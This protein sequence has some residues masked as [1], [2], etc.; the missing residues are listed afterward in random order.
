MNRALNLFVLMASAIAI[1]NCQKK[2]KDTLDVTPQNLAG[3]WEA[4]SITAQGQTVLPT[5]FYSAAKEAGYKGSV[6]KEQIELT[7]STL[8]YITSD[9]LAATVVTK[10]YTIDGKRVQP[11]KTKN[12]TLSGFEVVALKKDSMTIKLDN[13]Q[14]NDLV[15]HF[16]R[17]PKAE[18]ASEKLK[19]LAQNSFYQL[20]M[21]NNKFEETFSGDYHAPYKVGVQNRLNCSYLKHKE[22]RFLVFNSQILNV[23]ETTQDGAVIISSNSTDPGYNVR[24]EVTFNFDTPSEMIKV[25]VKFSAAST[26]SIEGRYQKNAT[27]LNFNATNNSICDLSVHRIKRNLSLSLDCSNVEIKTSS[28]GTPSNETAK[29]LLSKQCILEF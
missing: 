29:L 7:E 1:T 21:G 3:T 23:T 9:E 20:A 13:S 8:S 5:D 22:Q 28:L 27:N 12:M 17:I 4:T 26:N 16:S 6:A 2:A 19:P 24:A 11:E 18:L 15:I 25:P 14:P 10:K